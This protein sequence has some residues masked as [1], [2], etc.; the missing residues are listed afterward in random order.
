MNPPTHATQLIRA[1]LLLLFFLQ[2]IETERSQIK[3]MKTRGYSDRQMQE[4]GFSEAALHTPS[5]A[6][7][8]TLK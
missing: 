6:T 7:M 3:D 1:M 8:N 4:M 5:V 2:M